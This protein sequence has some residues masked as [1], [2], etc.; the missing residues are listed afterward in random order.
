MRGLRKPAEINH[1]LR[2]GDR[3]TEAELRRVVSGLVDGSVSDAQA[4]AFAMGVCLQGLGSAGR[5]ALT[6]A[7]RDSGQVMKW[8][9]ESPVID[10]HSTGGVGD[11]VSLVLAPALAACGASVPMISG[12]GLGHTGGT[13]DK[14]EAIPGLSCELPEDQFRRTVGQIGCAIVAASADIA[15]ADRRLYALRDESGTVQSLDLITASI[16]SKKLAAGL[17]ALVLDVKVGSGAFMSTMAEAE[18]LAIALVDTA[19]MAGCP[20]SAI[21]S[22]MDE[23]LAASMGNALEMI[24]VME[25]LTGDGPE[26]DLPEIVGELGGALLTQAGL[27]ETPEIGNAMVQEAI[28]DGSAAEVFGRMV[29][30]M[31][32]PSDFLTRYAD[33]LPAAR[34]MRHVPAPRSGFVSGIDGVALGNSVVALGGGRLRAQDRIDPGVGLS[35]IAALG[36]YV[37]QG[38]SLCMIHAASPEAADAAELAV[39]EA[40]R[41]SDSSP[42]VAPLIL[43]R[44]T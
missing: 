39:S 25:V 2:L 13:L 43:G 22:N 31:G 1:R 40:M 29:A 34:V 4:A 30:Q 8:Q 10:K 15:P 24:E 32:G 19:N 21:I 7:M 18:E 16:L 9:L 42:D 3:P 17:D 12:R 20:T 33:R 11:C 6:E 27:A 36:D 44:V 14:L 23:P 37:D 5:V 26:S 35:E 28:F 38:E 41:V